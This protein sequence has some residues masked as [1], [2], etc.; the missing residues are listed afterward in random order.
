M[1]AVI[2]SQRLILVFI[3]MQVS[4]TPN[5]VQNRRATGSER[6]F[7]SRLLPARLHAGG[8]CSLNVP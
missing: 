4:V 8:I 6:L 2:F 7:Y 3:R 1:G 5:S